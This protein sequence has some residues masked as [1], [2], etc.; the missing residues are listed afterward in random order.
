[1]LESAPGALLSGHEQPRSRQNRAYLLAKRALDLVGATVLLLALAPVF[2]VVALWIKWDSPGP[3][4]FRQTRVG[5]GGKHFTVYKFRSMIAHASEAVH[6]DYYLALLQARDDRS[7]AGVYKV[8]NDSRVTRAG[9]VIRKTSLDELPQLLNVLLGQMSLVGPRPPI[10]YEAEAYEPW[11]HERLAV[12]PGITGLWQVSGRSRLSLDEMFRLDI[13]YVR[14]ASLG[15][16]LK[17]LLLTLPTVLS[18]SKA[19]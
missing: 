10:P 16:D 5:R 2:A 18:P 19:A 7:D 4:I 15:L 8:P 6:R 13:E 1:M 17:I 9:V 11:V 12:T 3:V 14:T